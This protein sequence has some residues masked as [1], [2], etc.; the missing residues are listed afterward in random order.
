MWPASKNLLSALNL[1]SEGGNCWTVYNVQNQNKKQ[2]NDNEIQ[3]TSHPPPSP[4]TYIN[5]SSDRVF[6][7]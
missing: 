1:I 7:Y 4:N 5:S 2:E 3:I 6:I